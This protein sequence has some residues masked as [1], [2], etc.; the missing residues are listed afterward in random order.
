MGMAQAIA[1]SRA[2]LENARVNVAEI[3]RCGAVL[4]CGLALMLA[5]QTIPAIG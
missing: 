1:L 3:A 2:V 5:A 4:G